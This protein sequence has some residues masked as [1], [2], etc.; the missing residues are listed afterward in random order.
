[1]TSDTSQYGMHDMSIENIMMYTVVDVDTN[2]VDTSFL[3]G[4]AEFPLPAKYQDRSDGGHVA[5]RF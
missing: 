2:T 1:M 3:K 4:L 5:G